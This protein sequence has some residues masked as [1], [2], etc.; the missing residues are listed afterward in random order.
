MAGA[1]G[2]AAAVKL[3]TRSRG[4][5]WD[6][7]AHLIPHSERSRFAEID[8]I[9]VHYQEFGDRANP[10]IV[11]IHGY[12]A[13]TYVWKTTAPLLADAGFYVVALDLIGFGFSGKPASFDYAIQSQARIVSGLLEYLEIPRATLVAS[14]YG[15]AVALTLALDHTEQVEKLVLVSAVMNDEPK[16][17]PLL[18]LV[19]FRG[20]GEL[21]TP[22]IADSRFFLRRRMHLTLGRHNHHL[23]TDDRIAAIRRPL[24]NREGHHS[25]LATSRAW[26]AAEIENR[27]SEIKMPTLIIW[28]DQDNVVKIGSGHK[29]HNGI[30]NSH[31]VV[32]KDC[33][34]VPSEERTELFVELVSGF[35]TRE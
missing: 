10:P 29:L 31:F 20:I 16:D 27:L 14:S 3:L 22:F 2:A 6:D 4:V 1:L 30:A 32:L 33:G 28:G 26:R 34:H 24:C 5:E 23:I 15:G 9:R 19:A 17:H 7:V 21:L 25:L 8:G 18:R 35:S 11:L 13:S 12:T